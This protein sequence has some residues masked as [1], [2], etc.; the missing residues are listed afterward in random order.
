MIT[1]GNNEKGTRKTGRSRY[2]SVMLV[3]DHG[4]VIP[5][6]HFKALII[7]VGVVLILSL[8]ALIL[9]GVMYT[10]QRG[11]VGHL[12][13]QLEQMRAQS[14][15][16]RDDKDLYLTQ[17]KV[18]Q[19][20][21]G[22]LPRK[23]VDEPKTMAG[24][25][26][27]PADA[28]TP[29]KTDKAAPKNEKATP[30]KKEAPREVPVHKAEPRVQ[31]SADIR[32]F[33]VSYDNRQGVLTAEFRIYNTSQPK[34]RLKGQTVVVF[35]AIGDPPNQWAIV[36]SVPLHKETPDGKKGRPFNIRNY[37]TER[38][39]TLRRKNSPKYDIVAVYIF[40]DQSGALIVKRE[41][42]FNVDYSP[43]APPKPV[44]KPPEPVT[45]PPK[46]VAAPPKPAAK[47]QKKEPENST[48]T[49][50]VPQVESASPEQG[51]PDVPTAPDSASDEVE[52]P[53]AIDT[54]EPPS[55]QPHQETPQGQE[56]PKPQ[57]EV[58]GSTP[59]TQEASDE[60]TPSTPAAEPKP[61][62]EGETH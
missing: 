9:L 4:R 7:G 60:A 29:P 20:Q 38:F 55:G 57:S 42:P 31:W 8:C 33:N 43:P 26:P 28:K 23:P 5:F 6:R 15:K 61:A 36:P 14:A 30:E 11:Q 17:L 56:Q 62:Q 51:P 48:S 2:W 41:L 54:S 25:G 52:V 24:E 10:R 53:D 40:E 50:Q 19:M 46:P 13:K 37:Q 45:A 32:R 49:P 44:V 18:L 22:V 47:T 21:T 58:D 59:P 16:F 3:G 34:K 27:P 35:K 1:V 12:Q 39:K